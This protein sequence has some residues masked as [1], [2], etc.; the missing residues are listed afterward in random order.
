MRIWITIQSEQSLPSLFQLA[1]PFHCPLFSYQSSKDNEVI[2]WRAP[3]FLNLANLLRT[4]EMSEKKKNTVEPLGTDT[5]LI[6]TPLYHGQFPMS[7]QN[8]HI[9]SL[10]KPSIIRTLSN[11]DNGH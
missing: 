8:S 10:K 3:D 7:R 2:A 6:R 9:F 11:T 5:S 1:E 4:V